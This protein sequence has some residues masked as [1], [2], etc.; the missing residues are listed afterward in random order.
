[1]GK[2]PSVTNILQA[3]N[4][5][6]AA[7]KISATQTSMTEAWVEYVIGI[8]ALVLRVFSRCKIVVGW[9]WQADDYLAVLAIALFT[10]RR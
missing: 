1:M 6:M 7:N 5:R 8:P 9:K 4:G 2:Q 10:V 3:R